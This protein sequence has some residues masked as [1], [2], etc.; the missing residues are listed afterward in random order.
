[1][2]F[3]AIDVAAANPDNFDR[4]AIHRAAKSYG[5]SVPERTWLDSALPGRLAQ[6]PRK[7]SINTRRSQ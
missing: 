1:M 5:V 3:V 6:Y 4:V 2:H 7:N